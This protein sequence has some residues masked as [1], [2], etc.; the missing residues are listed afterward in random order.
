MGNSR[1]KC[2]LID[3]GPDGDKN[4]RKK[5]Q[6]GL[7]RP[8]LDFFAHELRV[9]CVKGAREKTKLMIIIIV[10]KAAGVATSDCDDIRDTLLLDRSNTSGRL[11]FR[12]N[13]YKPTC[14]NPF[15]G[16]IEAGS[17]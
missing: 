16:G 15:R 9:S 17:P 10:T 5:A 11:Q 8:Y 12:D 3:N 7:G 14:L 1:P 2:L 13:H 6:L 4:E